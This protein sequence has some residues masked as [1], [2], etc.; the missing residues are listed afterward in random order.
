MSR[1]VLFLIPLGL[2]LSLLP[3]LAQAERE[4]TPAAA[5]ETTRYDL[6]RGQRVFQKHCASCHANVLSRAPKA[7][8]PDE[9]RERLNQDL[10]ALI[11]HAIEGHEQ[12]PPK[13][14]FRGLS[15]EAVG[16]AVAYI[17]GRVEALIAAQNTAEPTAEA[18]DN[19]LETCSNAQQERVLLLR[20]F[21][22]LRGQEGSNG[23]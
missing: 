4:T 7:N 9:W 2:G 18:C 5:P 23:P 10:D 21:W 15:D 13:G 17:V 22:M 20:L 16:D 11:R 14:G 12:M 1:F 6:E 19:P 8:R 3:G